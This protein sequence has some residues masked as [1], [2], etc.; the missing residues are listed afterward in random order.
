MWRGKYIGGKQMH[1]GD[2]S[3]L[4]RVLGVAFGIAVVVGGTI[5]QGILRTPGLVA[6]GV[7]DP[8]LIIG[9]WLLGGFVSYVDAM[10]TV[11]LASSIRRTGG[12]FAFVDAAFGPILGLAVGIADWLAGIGVCGFVSVVFG[13]YL[14]R[15][16]IATS[17]PLGVLAALLVLAIGAIH[18]C[19]TKIGGLSQEVGSAI[20]AALFTILVGALCFAPRGVSVPSDIPPAAVTAGGIIVAIRGVFGTY[21][22]WNSA[23]YFCEEVYNPKRDIARATFMGILAVTAIYVLVNLA[24]LSVLSPAEMAGSNLVAADAA[25]RVFGPRADMI[26]TAISLISLVTLLNA[27]VMIYPRILF[28]LAR[29][30]EIP[31][32]AHV[33]DN[34]TP[35]LSMLVTVAAGALLATIGIYEMLL[36]FSVSLLAATGVCVNAAAVVM[37][38]RFP[39]LPRPYAMPFFPLPAIFAMV[40]NAALLVAFFVED[41][42]TAAQALAL[43]VVL[44]LGVFL[45]TQR[46]RI[47]RVTSEF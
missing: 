32:L 37:R 40:V 21:S 31:H 20:K 33:A 29:T 2:G 23:A 13:E 17:I 14:H 41:A 9:L 26:V 47:A 6:A 8:A 7:P 27:A 44:T 46:G 43:L 22:G 5:G 25:A 42:L 24:L 34:G 36:A 35:R 18:L 19:G 11:E 3:H 38:R 30:R 10:S 45:A 16:G 1:Q 12:P 28:A 15:L 39:T 4:L